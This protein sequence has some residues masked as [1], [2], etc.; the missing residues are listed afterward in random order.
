MTSNT[1]GIR[2]YHISKRL[3]HTDS[4]PGMAPNVSLPS[5]NQ[6]YGISGGHSYEC[7]ADV[8]MVL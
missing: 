1:L 4:P 8:M 7:Y 3:P 6:A 5:S 2:Y